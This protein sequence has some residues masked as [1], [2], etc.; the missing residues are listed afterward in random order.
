MLK[1]LQ[2]DLEI[3]QLYMQMLIR[4]SLYCIGILKELLNIALIQRINLNKNYK[5]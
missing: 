2:E 1:L 4:L 5:S 3:L